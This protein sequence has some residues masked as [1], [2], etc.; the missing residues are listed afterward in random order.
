[1]LRENIKVDDFRELL[2]CGK[3][4]VK[5]AFSKIPT[6]EFFPNE[7]SFSSGKL[8][9]KAKNQKEKNPKRVLLLSDYQ[10]ILILQSRLLPLNCVPRG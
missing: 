3:C 9:F 1:M 5:N 10:L 6:R 8:P 4:V 2:D 7:K